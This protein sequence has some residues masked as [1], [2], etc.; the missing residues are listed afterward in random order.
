M[1]RL[2]QGAMRYFERRAY[3]RKMVRDPPV[4]KEQALAIAK[5]EHARRGWTWVEPVAV[6][7]TG[8]TYRVCTNCRCRGNNTII[9]VDAVDG[10]VHGAKFHPY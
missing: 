6:W 3:H 9:S 5:D 8:L 4:S 7:R 1:K 10:Q 2:I